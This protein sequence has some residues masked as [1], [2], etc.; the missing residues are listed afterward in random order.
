MP[1]I[2]SSFFDICQRRKQ[3][4]NVYMSQ[5]AAISMA[6]LGGLLK[7]L[8]MDLFTTGPAARIAGVDR[9]TFIA[10]ANRLGIKPTATLE[11]NRAVYIKEDV[12]KIS[13][14]IRKHKES[15]D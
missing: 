8:N 6:D 13:K 14:A 1:H 3:R 7:R 11:G 2:A 5:F 15:K 4:G 9:R 10:W 12:E